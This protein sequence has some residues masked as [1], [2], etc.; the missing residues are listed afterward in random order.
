[1]FVHGPRTGK[2]RL[3]KDERRVGDNGSKITFEEYAIALANE[4]EKPKYHQE[5]FIV[6]Y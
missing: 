1:M 3:G 5:R 4:I 6:G 2:F